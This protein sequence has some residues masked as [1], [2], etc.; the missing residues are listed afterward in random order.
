LFADDGL[1]VRCIVCMQILAANGNAAFESRA[2]KFL[3]TNRT[4]SYSA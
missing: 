2:S 1:R 3:V 4:L